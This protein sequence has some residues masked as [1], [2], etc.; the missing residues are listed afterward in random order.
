[1]RRRLKHKL[2]IGIAVAAILAGATA[3]VVM[4]AQPGAPTHHRN[5][6][7]LATASAYLGVDAAQLRSELQSGKSLAEIANTTPG[8]SEAGL[9]AALEAADKQ[10][11]AAAS[12]NLPRL[13]TREITRVGGP[14]TGA[15][16]RG[17]GK[18]RRGGT[19][20]AAALYLGLSAAQLRQ[21]LHSGTTLAQ[22][23]K[24]TAGKSEAG[25]LEALLATRKAAL[26]TQVK[27]GALTQAQADETLPRLISRV[28]AAIHRVWHAR[29]AAH[30][31]TG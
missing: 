27:A 18:H 6:G 23:A 28:T 14:K 9:V 29:S 22:L 15:R 21:Q 11:L 13:V 30:A 5:S 3:A 26:A 25:L 7:A 24:A 2:M 19:V 20:S 17:A 10:K 8:K 4:A 12:A 1:M 31:P 16:H